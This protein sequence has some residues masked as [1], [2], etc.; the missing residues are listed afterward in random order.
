MY[1]D[2]QKIKEV[3]AYKFIS[4]FS[5]LEITGEDAGN[6]LNTQTTNETIDIKLN[7]GI[8]NNLVDRKPILKHIL[9]FIN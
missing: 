3:G 5:V 1:L 8:P 2:Y 4:E 7:K 9:L 6:Y